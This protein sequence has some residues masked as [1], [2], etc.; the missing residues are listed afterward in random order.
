M[1]CLKQYSTRLVI[2]FL[3]SLTLF[4]G[5]TSTVFADTFEFNKTGAS[6]ING[7]A[8]Y[9]AQDINIGQ[10][11]DTV[12]YV[13]LV[14]RGNSSFDD[15]SIGFVPTFFDIR[16]PA[17]DYCFNIDGDVLKS[18]AG[19]L[20]RSGGG[21]ASIPMFKN[22][23]Y[24]SNG[25]GSITTY[26]FNQGLNCNNDYG[27]ERN[28]CVES[29]IVSSVQVPSGVVKFN[30]WTPPPTDTTTRVISL[31]PAQDAV[32]DTPTT[33]L[34]SSVYN[35]V[36]M[37]N[38]YIVSLSYVEPSTNVDLLLS[39]AINQQFIFD[40]ATSTS[41]QSFSTTTEPLLSGRWL[42]NAVFSN[43]TN[44]SNYFTATS[45]TFVVGTTTTFYSDFVYSTSTSYGQISNDCEAI[46]ASS[47][48]SLISKSVCWMGDRIGQTLSY[49]FVPSGF[50]IDK[51]IVL[52]DD[53]MDRVPFGYFTRTKEL[54]N[55]V[56]ASTTPAFNIPIPVSIKNFLFDK[57]REMMGI[58]LPVLW[59]VRMYIRLKDIKI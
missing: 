49:L 48:A 47:T 19:P 51:Y 14:F 27:V 3:A 38:K 7:G 54:L 59:V 20:I 57:I 58:A 25:C 50:F 36:E 2:S 30:G 53:M 15:G 32:I 33:T 11:I 31:S 40:L 34:S 45:T 9:A 29:A 43:G 17:G 12:E 16:T 13:D 35:Q 41:D 23:S 46:Y 8:T 56:N 26:R 52:K 22:P 44:G 28:Y 6:F 5:F 1:Q 55:S 39:D 10:V 21:T 42:I 37:Y 18:I 24:T 4:L